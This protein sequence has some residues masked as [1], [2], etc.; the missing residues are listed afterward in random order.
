MRRDDALT[1]AIRYRSATRV[2]C[3]PA[4]TGALFACL[5]EDIRRP[6]LVIVF[7]LVVAA[8]DEMLKV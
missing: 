6:A 4:A 8:R 2:G 5:P 3:L 7:L 1:R